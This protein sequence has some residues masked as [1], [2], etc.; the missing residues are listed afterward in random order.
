MDALGMMPNASGH[1]STNS[2]EV[3]LEGPL[4]EGRSRDIFAHPLEAD[5]LVKVNRT[6]WARTPDFNFLELRNYHSVRD[7]L[8]DYLTTYRPGLL[9]TIRGMGLMCRKVVDSD[10]SLSRS[11]ADWA[12]NNAGRM[13]VMA[14]HFERF[15]GR[16]LATR[17]YFFDF[18]DGNFLVQQTDEG[19]HLKFIDLK[20]YR[21][22][23]SLVR[24]TH[25]FEA[26]ARR[27]MIRRRD[28]FLTRWFNS[29]TTELR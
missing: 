10:G 3:V 1:P 26:A 18:N 5:W 16:L 29:T 21:L 9:P 24:L 14:K 27:K 8:S 11:W 12:P 28:R 17:H 25:W 4:F 19:L 2:P 13:P 22:D 6:Q 20:S 23:R 15:F 7:D